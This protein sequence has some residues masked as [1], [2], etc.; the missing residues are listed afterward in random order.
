MD[1]RRASEIEYDRLFIKVDRTR[2][3]E[4][5]FFALKNKS[6]EQLLKRLRVEFEG[7]PVIDAGGATREWYQVR[8]F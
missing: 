8:F 4:S 3:F 1:R 6:A 7:E 2:L 5:S